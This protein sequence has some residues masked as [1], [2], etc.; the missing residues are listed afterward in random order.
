MLQSIFPHARAAQDE[1]NEITKLSMTQNGETKTRI[2][3]YLGNAYVPDPVIDHAIH[4]P[5]FLHHLLQVKNSPPLL[6]KLIK[7]VLNAPNTAYS[8]PRRLGLKEIANA[9]RSIL[10]A[11]TSESLRSSDAVVKIRL[12]ACYSCENRIKAPNQGIYKVSKHVLGNEVCRLCGCHIETKARLLKEQCP[13]PDKGNPGFN[14][15]GQLI[16]LTRETNS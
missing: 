16:P 9:T 12:D 10:N 1:M 11:A 15:W 6:D 7:E 2:L 14:R 4:D 5:L 3:K 13:A 8:Q